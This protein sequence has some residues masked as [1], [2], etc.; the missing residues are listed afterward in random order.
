MTDRTPGASVAIGFSQKTCL[1]ASTAA[2]RWKGRNPGG[3]ARSTTSTPLSKTFLY[4]SRPINE[5][6]GFT[7]I[8]LLMASSFFSDLKLPCRRSS[9]MSP[10][11]VNIAFLS[12]FKACSAAPVPRPPHPMSPTLSV[13]EFA[14]KSAGFESM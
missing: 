6:S 11:A 8:L 7:V 4:E 14:A 9:K 3:V 1:P 2:F 5:V 13:S 10:M 12:A